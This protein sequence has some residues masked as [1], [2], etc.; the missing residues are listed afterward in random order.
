MTETISRPAKFPPW[1]VKR[2]P[3]Q[4]D[5]GV[6]DLLSGLK[7]NTVC[8]EARCPN[9]GE[10]WS[11]GTATF[12]LMGHDCTRSCPYCHIATRRPPV[13]DPAEPE[14]VAE[15]AAR[16]DLKHIV[17]T[18]VCRDDLPDG[19]AAHWVATVQAIRRRSPAGIEGLIPDFRH[20]PGALEQVLAA[21][22]DVLNHN[23]ECVPRLYRRVRPQGEYR[24]SLDVLA[25]ARE[26]YPALAT[27]S[28]LMVGMGEIE[29]EVFEVMHDLREHADVDI[30]TIG[31]YLQPTPTHH[32]VDRHVHPDE[33][34][35][36]EDAG[37]EMGFRHVF[38]G[39]FVRSSYRADELAM[40]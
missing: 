4:Y 34:A 15:A 6:R 25:R 9:L 24:L 31:Q 2:L 3:G 39:P 20:K 38:S 40:A 23:V 1:L 21:G 10:C 19:G 35:R 32:P 5:A 14:R 13:L 30:I 12:L 8:Q 11:R 16:L 36:Y 22:M 28:G 17:L 26:L 37:R 29:E 7:L 33:F 27:K 18:S